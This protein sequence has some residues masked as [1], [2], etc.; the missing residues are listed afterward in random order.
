M[1]RND[2]QYE[3]REKNLEHCRA[4][5]RQWNREHPEAHRKHCLKAAKKEQEEQPDIRRSRFLRSR[6]GITLE[7]KQ[8]LY[9]RQHGL[10]ALCSK[11]LPEDFRKAAVDHD[12][13]TKIVRGLL[14]KTPCNNGLGYFENT[15]FRA[16][17]EAYLE[18]V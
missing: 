7:D 3:W 18:T 11:P 13:M 8:Q 17:A 15:E 2:T 14:H 16:Q 6:Y 12:H 1:G 4:Q 10:C 5:N 9:A